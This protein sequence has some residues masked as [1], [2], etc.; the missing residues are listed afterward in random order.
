MAVLRLLTLCAVL[1]TALSFVAMAPPTGNKPLAAHRVQAQV[2]TAAAWGVQQ[3]WG[4]VATSLN[5]GAFWLWLR[6]WVELEWVRAW[7]ASLRM[8]YAGMCGRF[9]LLSSGML[10][11]DA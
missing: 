5:A 2:P 8:T 6:A 4:R 10:N 7:I 9:L 3:R 1:S 11:T